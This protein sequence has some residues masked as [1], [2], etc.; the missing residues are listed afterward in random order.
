MNQDDENIYT[1]IQLVLPQF[2]LVFFFQF[3]VGF[4]IIENAVIEITTQVMME[5]IA[6]HHIFQIKEDLYKSMQ[7]ILRYILKE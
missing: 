3:F 1:L 5:N 2:G 6:P 4:F 7:P